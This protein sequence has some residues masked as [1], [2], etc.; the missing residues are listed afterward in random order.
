TSL[1]PFIRDCPT[2]MN[3]KARVIPY[4]T[5]AENTDKNNPLYETEISNAKWWAYDLPGN[6][7]WIA[8]IVCLVLCF[9]RGFTVFAAD[10]C[11]P[12]ALMLLG[13]SELIR[14]RIAG[15]DRVLPRSYLLMGFGA[16]TLGG[17]LG[18]A[19]SVTG[20]IFLEKRLLPALM[21]AG[22]ALCCI[23]AGLLYRG[24]RKR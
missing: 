14:E 3:C 11:I 13:V 5:N 15:L 9:A 22:G 23:F 19:V 24:Y 1:P 6:T 21:L 7:G 2:R 4:R 10:A 16:L 8:Y 17:A 12:A 20:L 18:A